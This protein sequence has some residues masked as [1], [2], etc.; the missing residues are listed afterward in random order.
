[1]YV[2]LSTNFNYINCLC[3]FMVL[4]CKWD[5]PILCYLLF[6]HFLLHCPW[7]LFCHIQ[8]MVGSNFLVKAG[9][10]LY[11]RMVNLLHLGIHIDLLFFSN[12]EDF[13][14]P[15]SLVL[16]IPF[17]HANNFPKSFNVLSPLPTPLPQKIQKKLAMTYALR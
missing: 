9:I 2:L 4:V 6:S 14:L 3:G 1:M 16:G 11:Y 17:L 5:I 15:K 12:C 13:L 8:S 7:S 10:A